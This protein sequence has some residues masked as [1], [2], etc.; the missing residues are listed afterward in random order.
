MFGLFCAP[1]VG[2]CEV[3]GL[4]QLKLILFVR[5]QVS[6]VADAALGQH[7]AAT[8]NAGAARAVLV[9][10]HRREDFTG[11]WVAYASGQKAH[12]VIQKPRG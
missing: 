2:R 1:F 7:R 4:Q 8:L 3:T 6:D 9:F 10:G 12:A 5:R 11:R